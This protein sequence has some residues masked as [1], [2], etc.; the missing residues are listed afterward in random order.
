[1]KV[2]DL[3]YNTETFPPYHNEFGIIVSCKELKDDPDYLV[4][5]TV[6]CP[7]GYYS[8]VADDLQLVTEGDIGRWK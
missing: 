3:V 8:A 6:W 5:Y 7:E 4:I 2:G 1:M